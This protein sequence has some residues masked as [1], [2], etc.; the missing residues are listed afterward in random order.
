MSSVG[1]TPSRAN[2]TDFGGWN[3]GTLGNPAPLRSQRY[4]VRNEGSAAVPLPTG[5]RVAV[6]NADGPRFAVLQDL[7]GASLE[8]GGRLTFSISFDGGGSDGTHRA[9]VLVRVPGL[10]SGFAIEGTTTP[11]SIH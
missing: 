9:T 11:I 1:A 6:V 5:P 3:T 2:G 7:T 4:E 8:P 10:E